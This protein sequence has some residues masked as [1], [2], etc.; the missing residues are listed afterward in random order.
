MTIKSSCILSVV[1]MVCSCAVA[2]GGEI[3]VAGPVP[4]LIGTTCEIGSLEFTFNSFT[5]DQAHGTSFSAE[6]F[7]LTPVLNG[8]SIGFDGGPLSIT[9]DGTGIEFAEAA[10]TYTVSAIETTP[11]SNVVTG[12]GATGG[13]FWASPEGSSM[14][15]YGNARCPR[16]W[17]R[18]LHDGVAGV[19]LPGI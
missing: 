18:V 11:G 10:L 5:S 6:D 15:A 17:L 7:T 19:S 9:S 14:A 4:T 12:I 8:F 13:S 3:C 2:Q 1:L 16:G